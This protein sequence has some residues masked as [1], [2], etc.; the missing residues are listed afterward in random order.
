MGSADDFAGAA[1]A[2]G[3]EAKHEARKEGE[4]LRFAA[5]EKARR[6]ARTEGWRSDAFDV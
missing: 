1:K 5:Q 6:E 3:Q 2:K 4:S